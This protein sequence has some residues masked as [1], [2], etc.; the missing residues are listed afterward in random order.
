MSRR[1]G[2]ARLKSN[3]AKIF[4]GEFSAIVIFAIV[5]NETACVIK[6]SLCI[7]RL[8]KV[9]LAS[10]LL[11]EARSRLRKI[12]TRILNAVGA[13]TS[14][15][16]RSRMPYIGELDIDVDRRVRKSLRLALPAC[17]MHCRARARRRRVFLPTLAIARAR[18]ALARSR[19]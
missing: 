3:L 2:G 10:N 12:R 14:Q 7:C 9:M 1:P 4:I 17:V 16:Q 6:C 18:Q 15:A 19:I 11:A 13:P 5:S 8:Q